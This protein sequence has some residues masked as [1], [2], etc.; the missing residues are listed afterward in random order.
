MEHHVFAVWDFMSLLKSLQR[1]LTCVEVPW[2]PTGPTGS[3]R[4]INDIVLVEESDELGDGFISHFELYVRR[5]AARPARTPPSSTRFSTCCGP[6]AGDRRRWPRRACR[7]RRP[8]SP[9]TTWRLIETTPVHCQAAAFAFGR[10]DLIPDMFTPGRHGQRAA[11]GGWTRSSTTWPGTSRS[12]ASS[13]RRWPCRCSPTCAATTT[14][15]G[16]SAR[17]TVNAALAARARL[18]DGILAADQGRGPRP[19]VIRTPTRCR[20]Y[21]TVRLIRRFEERAIELVRAGEIVGGIHPYIGQEAIAAGVCAALR[22]GRPRHQHPPRARARAGQGRRPGPD[23]GRAGRPGHRAEPGPRRLDARRR[24]RPSACSAPT[25][26]SGAGA[27]IAT[28]RGVGAP[29]RRGTDRVAVSFFGDGAV[30]QGVLLEA[31]NLAALWRVP[32]RVR[33]REQRLRHHHAGRAARSPAAITGRAAAFGIPAV[34]RGRHGPGGGLRRRR[35]RRRAGPR[36][37]R[38]R[39]VLECPT[40]RFDAHHTFE[41]SAAAATTAPTR[42]SP[43]GGPATRCRSRAPGSPAAD[44]AGVD[45][46]V[47]AVLDDGGRVRPGQPRAGPGRRAGPPLRQRPDRPGPGAGLMPRLSYLQGA[48]PGARATR[49]PRDRA[50]FLLGEDVGVARHQRHH[51]AAASGSA[52]DRV[53]GH[54]RCRSRRSPASPPAPRWPGGGR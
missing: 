25:P 3:R 48:Q 49:W 29:G 31:F 33:L 41:H 1:S 5:H 13:T 12:T 44:R 26:S 24:L 7:R 20:L 43:P 42:R 21:R 36:R 28:G 16:R 14:S 23:A 37:R 54:R 40:Y 53:R 10:E 51:R 9:R 18:W 2:I 34:H 15:S 35:R 52:P 45:A 30:N 32:V 17:D 22:A 8:S 11:G 4:L 19:G 6:A 46:E 47:E 50:V 27:A 39:A 38:A